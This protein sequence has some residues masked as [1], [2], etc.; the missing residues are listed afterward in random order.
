MLEV[1]PAITLSNQTT[2]GHDLRSYEYI[3]TSE[4]GQ[5]ME[6]GTLNYSEANLSYL[7]AL[8]GGSPDKPA[9]FNYY[10]FH[11]NDFFPQ[12]LNAYNISE[13]KN[14]Y[15]LK[16][17]YNYYDSNYETLGSQLHESNLPN[18]YVI[19]QHNAISQI[20]SF[21]TGPTSL[22]DPVFYGD[23][24]N[25]EAV[26]SLATLSGS[27]NSQLY[28]SEAFDEQAPMIPHERIYG[29]E[30]YYYQHY[31]NIQRYAESEDY[32][33][34][35]DKTRN[36]FMSF[37]R[38]SEK[39]SAPFYCRLRLNYR[40]KPTNRTQGTFQSNQ[41]HGF[42]HK[43][44]PYMFYFYHHIQ[45]TPSQEREL[46]SFSRSYSL[47]LSNSVQSSETIGPK[48]VKIYP[49]MLDNT[50]E[51]A[52]NSFLG[53]DEITLFDDVRYTDDDT[54]TDTFP[55]VD[56][57]LPDIDMAENR[58]KRF[59]SRGFGWN[60]WK[61]GL[62]KF[63]SGVPNYEPIIVCFKI[64]KYSGT[65]AIPVQTYYMDH[66][67]KKAG[68]DGYSFLEFMDSQLIY[69]KKYRYK[70]SAVCRLD[71]PIVQV[72]DMFYS[73]ADRKLYSVFINS[74]PTTS[75]ADG[76]D[77]RIE[78]R[79]V[80]DFLTKYLGYPVDPT[81]PAIS[82]Y[83]IASQAPLAQPNSPAI[84]GGSIMA[85]EVIQTENDLI[86]PNKIYI[87]TEVSTK[88]EFME[89]ELFEESVDAIEPIFAPPEVK[90]YNENGR[91][92][93]LI[94]KAQLNYNSYRDEYIPITPTDSQRIQDYLQFFHPNGTYDFRTL[95]GEGRFELRRLSSPPDEY[96]DF[97]TANVQTFS[98]QQ[99]NNTIYSVLAYAVNRIKPNKKYYYIL[100]TINNHGVFSNPTSVFEIELLQDSDDTF[101]IV[102]EYEFKNNLTNNYSK[103]GRRYLQIKVSNLQGLIN[104]QTNEF[105]EATTADDI[106]SVNLGP[107]D[108]ENKVWGKT[109][110]IR[111]TSEKT[112]KK[113]DLNVSFKHTDEPN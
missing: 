93:D 111:V 17:I 59:F 75:A 50:F 113:I 81:K 3:T 2:T 19:K 109:F 60:I 54:F 78:S 77:L 103:S 4:S 44:R 53:R 42:Q 70:V 58:V 100:R 98:S 101:I 8:F 68:T 74:N 89:I 65:S 90:F 79:L 40:A 64:E 28:D 61:P 55:L 6:Y 31:L 34:F 62:S 39:S 82:G 63:I 95:N 106:T 11:F 20:P 27:I 29:S 25:E 73:D 85:G 18:H 84:Q 80:S 41:I 30:N 56:S 112:G 47:G 104:E 52:S 1:S 26:I 71:T 102:E 108:L 10:N 16:F 91:V 57:I 23:D 87:S 51:Q 22:Y 32:N 69:G 7:T 88:A 37:N 66:D 96:L 97:A 99:P 33:D 9:A 14:N 48:N 76:G 105:D 21:N 49:A 67:I 72:K 35:K 110:K 5:P 86:V 13:M 92:N 12:R 38:S 36:C 15:D 94:V 83:A 107:S 43:I 45:N 46:S 24:I